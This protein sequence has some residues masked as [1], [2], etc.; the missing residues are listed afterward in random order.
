MRDDLQELVDEVS[1]VLAAPVT[2]EDADFTLLAFCAHDDTA[3]GTMDA[4]R[5][6]SILTRGS[7]PP[8]RAWFETFGIAAAEGPLRTPADPAAGILTRLVIPVR[9]DGRTHGYLWLLDGGRIDPADVGDPALA[10]AV[11]LAAEAGRLLAERPGSEDDL[12]RPL[13]E[14]LDPATRDQGL[15]TLAAA[16]G[17]ELPLVLV[18]LVPGPEG[19]P[20][21]WRRPRAGAVTAVLDDAAGPVAAA[22]VPLNRAG[23]LR[24][25]GALAAGALAGLPR[26]STAGV[27]QVRA[28]VAGL[29]GQWTQAQAA[30]RVARAV[31]ALSPVAH[32]AELGAWRPV[33]EL[34]GPDPAV[35][36]LLADAVLSGTAEVFLDCAGSAS[37]AATALRIHRQT[38]YYRLSRIEALTGLDLADGGARLL[39]HTSLRAARL[40]AGR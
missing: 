12:G 2:L 24:P 21:H 6:R 15:R 3:A 38:L 33:T 23:D 40:A 4:V 37:R 35:A 11:G 20:A 18:A 34:A 14:A 30:A 7:P 26:G 29:P 39:L 27:S 9:H 36:P 17:D 25:A 16:L 1:R 31:P 22:L 13:A 19:L 8:T 32:W 5:T 28:G 10:A